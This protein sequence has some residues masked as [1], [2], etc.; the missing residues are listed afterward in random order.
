[1]FVYTKLCLTQYSNLSM[2]ILN[3]ENSYK[4][5]CTIKYKICNESMQ[6][7]FNS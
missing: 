1:M 6:F 4:I 2:Y 3:F 5:V 7:K